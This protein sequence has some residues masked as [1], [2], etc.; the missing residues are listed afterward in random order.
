[1]PKHAINY[2]NTIIYKLC[3]NDLSITDCYVGHT[4]D[5]IKRKYKH[6]NSCIN[7]NTKSYN[8]KVYKTIRENGGWENWSMVQLE[9][10]KCKTN[11]EAAAYERYWYE[12]LKANLNTCM[13]NRS[14][15]ESKRNYKKNH[16]DKINESFNCECGGKYTYV[17]KAKHSKNKKHQ[18]YINSI[19]IKSNDIL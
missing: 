12:Q 18:D 1:M 9:Q 5:F 3:C 6:K 15:S 4:T 2:E 11:L 17:N 13:P 10:V 19:E 14:S 16:P 8:F 7:E